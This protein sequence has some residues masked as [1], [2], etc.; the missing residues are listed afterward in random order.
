M[1]GNVKDPSLA[2]EGKRKID[3]VNESMPV[4][5][6][7]EE[8]MQN[9]LPFEGVKV[10]ISIHKKKKTAR[11]A[12]ALKEGGAEVYITSSNPPFHSG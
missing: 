1:K 7:I 9:E 3:W 4:M 12:I 2:P 6:R 10:G 5:A 11:L 8:K